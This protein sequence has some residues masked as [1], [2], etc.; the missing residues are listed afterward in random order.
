M[1]WSGIE[2]LVN[3]PKKFLDGSMG[4][5]DVR[6]TWIGDVSVL[7]DKRDAGEC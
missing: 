5:W 2:Y 3:D 7:S 4:A 1:Y 6:D